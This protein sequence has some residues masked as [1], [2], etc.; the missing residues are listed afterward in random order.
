M[1]KIIIAISILVSYVI[2][3]ILMYD[4]L[5]FLAFTVGIMAILKLAEGE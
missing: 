2:N 5:T 1:V 3:M 4:P